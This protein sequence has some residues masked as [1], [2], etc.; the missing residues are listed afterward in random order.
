M[1]MT[2][3]EFETAKVKLRT[4]SVNTVDLARLVLVDGLSIQEAATASGTSRQNANQGMKR[5]MA[6]LEGLPSDWVFVE[7]WMP[8]SMAVEVRRMADEAKRKREK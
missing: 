5:V 2:A 1:K 6:L 8:S 7:E 4:L 3:D